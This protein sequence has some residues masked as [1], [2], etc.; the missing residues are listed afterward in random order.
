MDFKPV[1]CVRWSEILPVTTTRVL[2]T[3]NNPPF[4][5]LQST[6]Q[7]IHKC[8]AWSKPLLPSLTR[9]R[10][11]MLLV[12]SL[13]YKNTPLANTLT[14]RFSLVHRSSDIIKSAST[15]HHQGRPRKSPLHAL[16]CKKAELFF[17]SLSGMLHSLHPLIY[18]ILFTLQ[19][20]LFLFKFL[21]D[22][23]V[24]MTSF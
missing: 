23:I 21:L 3:V 10:W 6:I 19:R 17:Q 13:I 5:F 1:S 14:C 20:D 11:R 24:I 16:K 9:R 8:K 4:Q 12:H 22:L 18:Q 7:Q 2:A 15:L